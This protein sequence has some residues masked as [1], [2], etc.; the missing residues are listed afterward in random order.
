MHSS[1]A[2]ANYFLKIAKDEGEELTHMKVQ[3]L[4]YIAYGWHF[5]FFNKPMLSETVEAWRWGPVFPVLYAEFKHYANK[6]ITKPGI[7]PINDVEEEEKVT[8]PDLQE[9]LQAVWNSYKSYSP[10]ELSA[11]THQ[12]D[13]PW[14]KTIEKHSN[15]QHMF[16][17][18]LVIS[19]DLIET[20]YKDL[21]EKLPD[22]D[23]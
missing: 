9:F 16:P 2:I 6:P 19:Q 18:S 4:V 3:K 17:S 22:D 12:E 7:V 14:R 23:D 1:I 13:T 8:E 5:A 15:Y 10:I 20:Y 21:Y 11:R